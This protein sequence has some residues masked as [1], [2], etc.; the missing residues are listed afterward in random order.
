MVRRREPG[1]QDGPGTSVTELPTRGLDI[2][3]GSLVA[4]P[5][6]VC[7]LALGGMPTAWSGW[8][9]LFGPIL[10]SAAILACRRDVRV[11]VLLLTLALLCVPAADE[12][13]GVPSSP[14][15]GFISL[16]PVIAA[17]WVYCVL[18]SE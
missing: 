2:V 11:A 6:L 13:F 10:G 4:V 8:A 1:P 3:A 14:W 9:A 7:L 17:A 15:V 18:G 12:I 5:P 16:A